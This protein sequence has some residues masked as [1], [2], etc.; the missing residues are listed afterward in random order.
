[1]AHARI[2]HLYDCDE[3]TFWRQ[4]M[5]DEAF[6]S[7]L[8]LEHLHFD[9]WK[10]LRLDDTETQLVREVSVRPVTGELPAPLKKLIGQNFGYR[11]LGR[12]DKQARR[13][14]F[15]IFPNTLPDKLHIRGD[16]QVTPRGE[17][18][19]ER[20]LELDVEAKVF[21]VGGMIEKRIIGDT[22]DSFD[23]GHRFAQRELFGS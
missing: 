10:I 17:S 2:Q 18:Q 12:F 13:Y 21:G 14:S 3:A 11:E 4:V 1:M 6:N 22:R 5:F 9:E 16:I 15:E 20:T 7:R 19:C 8:Y 23:K